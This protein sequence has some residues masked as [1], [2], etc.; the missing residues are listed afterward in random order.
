MGR[1]R[2]CA[3][4]ARCA[5]QL[6]SFSRADVSEAVEVMRS[7]RELEIGIADAPIVVLAR[8]YRTQKVLTLDHRHFRAIRPTK[9]K[10]F[11]I[12]PS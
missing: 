11:Q 9:G 10:P 7:Y 8:R 12:Y 1:V 3:G 5:Y 6:E 2:I 4:S